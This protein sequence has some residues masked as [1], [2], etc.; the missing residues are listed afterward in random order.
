M[1]FC[2]GAEVLVFSCVFLQSLALNALTGIFD[3]FLTISHVFGLSLPGEC[4]EIFS[5]F[6]KILHQGV[7][8]ALHKRP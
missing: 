4:F 3:F 8:V 6:E 5:M 1:F 7:E 2:Y